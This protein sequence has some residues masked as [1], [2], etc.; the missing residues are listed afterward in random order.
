MN[1]KYAGAAL[2]L[3]LAVGGC[4]QAEALPDPDAVMKTLE[5]ANTAEIANL[6]SGGVPLLTGN[7]V[8]EISSNWVSAAYFVG[9]AR[10]AR[11]TNDAA[12]L[13][14]LTEVAEHFN[15]APRGAKNDIAMLD[16]DNIAI[17]DLYEELY[18][19]RREPGMLAP[20]R[21]RLDAQRPHLTREPAPEHLV[22]W[23]CDA[24]FMA[25]PVYTRMA[26]LTGDQSYLGAMDV[27]W[28]RS[29]DRLY[30]KKL[31]LVLRDERFLERKDENGQKI[32]WSRGDGWVMAGIARVLESL[33]ADYPSRPRYIALFKNMA[34]KLAT[35]QRKEGLWPTSL[36]NDKAYPDAE[37]SGTAFYTYALAWGINHNI[38][39]RKKY[40][41]HVLKGWTALNAQLL[42]SGLLG[43]V[44]KTGDQPA[45]TKPE[46]IGLYGQ[47]GFLLAGLEVMNLGKPATALP[48]AEPQKD[49]EQPPVNKNPLAYDPASEPAVQKLPKMSFQLAPPKAGEDKPAAIV[50]YA[51]YRYDDILWEN[52]RI[53]HR[54]YGPA[55]EKFEPP[56]GS[57]IDAWGK[58]VR[59][60]FMERQLATGRQH[61]FHG[62][63][64]D[65]YNVGTARGDGGLG[66]WAD[67]KLWVSRNYKT[68][69]ILN[70]GPEV[71]SFSLDYA[72]WPVGVNRKVWEH[73]ELSLPLGTNF[74]KQVSTISSD[75]PSEL[76]V[77]IGL[78][79]HA[80]SD[81]TAEHIWDAK[82]GKLVIWEKADPDK[83]SMGLALMVNPAQV[84]GFVE[85]AD[86]FLV[87]VKVSPGKPFTYYS[88]ACWDKGLDFHS[89]SEWEH[90]VTEQ[91]PTF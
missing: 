22:W 13:Q 28:W 90:Y 17:G 1:G 20:L 14:F 49:K 69:K 68:Y 10:Y 53:A 79:K 3:F 72:P 76:I 70:P 46:E 30:D 88:G 19:R 47:G 87:L 89:R 55:L 29:I 24:L 84:A 37:T 56:S 36:L 5:R 15:Y 52:D 73:R 91:K 27:Q 85:E 35:L 48:I 12:T 75:D 25:P 34:A 57:G 65:Y 58:R 38:L 83:G 66:I 26:A 32:V 8:R 11:L 63:G 71:A 50:R 43:L 33:P 41:P 74:T 60:P 77:A 9:A 40:L 64:I 45:P 31:K 7:T 6:R 81:K 4:A 2:A 18:A 67:N 16:A 59:Y 23:W 42:P 61:D 44:Q 54:L 62:D 86:N 21:L 39:E 80:T 78:N 51:P 82:T